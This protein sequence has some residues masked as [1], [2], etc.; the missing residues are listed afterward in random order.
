MCR[1]TWKGGGAAEELDLDLH[2]NL[3]AATI[4]DFS[5]FPC[6]QDMQVL[7]VIFDYSPL[8]AI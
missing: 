6:S 2:I 7:F 3:I 4:S 1:V 8:G 5:L